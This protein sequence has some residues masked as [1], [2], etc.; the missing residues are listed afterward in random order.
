MKVLNHDNSRF[1]GIGVE[2]DIEVKKTI[3]GVRQK[4]DEQ[5]ERAVEFI[6]TGK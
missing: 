5:F 2:P 4:R 3:E 6:K 1:H